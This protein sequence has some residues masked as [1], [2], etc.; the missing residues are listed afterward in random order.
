MEKR[1]G[2]AVGE[3]DEGRGMKSEVSEEI[4]KTL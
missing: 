1:D 4:Y 3:P 2:E